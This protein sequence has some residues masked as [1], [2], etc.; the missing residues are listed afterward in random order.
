M[1]MEIGIKKPQEQQFSST[2]Q[3]RR[4]KKLRIIFPPQAKRLNQAPFVPP[5]SEL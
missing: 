1:D 3:L 4:E 2:E 5:L